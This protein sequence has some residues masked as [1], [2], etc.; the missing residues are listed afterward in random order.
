MTGTTPNLALPYPELS[1]TADVPR[2]IKALADALDTRG[3]QIVTTLPSSPVDGQE[4]LFRPPGADGP[5]G[6]GTGLLWAFRYN[7]A[8]TNSYK[9]EYIGGAPMYSLSD[10]T[11]RQ[12]LSTTYVTLTAPLPSLTLPLD[13]DYD[14]AIEASL[15]VV[16]PGTHDAL[17]SYAFTGAVAIAASDV[18]AIE[19]HNLQASAR[20]AYRHTQRNAGSIVAEQARVTVSGA[21]LNVQR[22]ALFVTPVR[23]G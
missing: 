15:G 3:R 23:V 8:S 20:R 7:A 17:L 5:G 21:Q 11:T 10:G 13:G 1:D 9:W 6:T 22:R 4:I 12:T 2:D 18:W 19:S 16:T 14:I